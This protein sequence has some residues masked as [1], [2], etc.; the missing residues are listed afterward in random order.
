MTREEMK[1]EGSKDRYEEGNE[2]EEVCVREE[3]RM[4]ILEKRKRRKKI[5]REQK[6]KE[7]KMAEVIKMVMATRAENEDR[8][9]RGRRGKWKDGRRVNEPRTRE[10]PQ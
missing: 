5:K 9:R 3:R 7:G 2:K 8:G 6:E 4:R 1:V 10:S